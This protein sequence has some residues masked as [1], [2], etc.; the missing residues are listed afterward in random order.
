MFVDASVCVSCDAYTVSVIATTKHPTLAP[1][2]MFIATPP[3]VA[4]TLKL[5]GD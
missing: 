2:L 1:L 5:S 3:N 4:A